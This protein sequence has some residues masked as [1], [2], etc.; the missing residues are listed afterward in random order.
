M[1]LDVSVFL[2]KFYNYR[3]YRHF[4]RHFCYRMYRSAT[5]HSEKPNR[6]NFRV[7]NSH[8]QRGHAIIAIPDAAFSG[9]SVLQP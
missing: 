3:V 2:T 9:G 4:F 8:W 5:T 6:R 1:F 7:W